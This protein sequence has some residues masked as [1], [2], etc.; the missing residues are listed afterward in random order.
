MQKKLFLMVASAIFST[1]AMDAPR[2]QPKM[3]NF[4]IKNESTQPIW[5]AVKYSAGHL[6]AEGP[7]QVF[8]VGPGE[9]LSL[10]AEN[11][12]I[13]FSPLIWVGQPPRDLSVESIKKA[14]HYTTFAGSESG[15]KLFLV[16]TKEGKLRPQK[17]L[18]HADQVVNVTDEELQEHEPYWPTFR[19]Q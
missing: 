17:N 5:L 6:Y 11:T 1:Q 13:E 14:K 2:Q 15:K 3:T 7:K 10:R 12:H 4:E 9:V 19:N 16:W 8:Q 18:T